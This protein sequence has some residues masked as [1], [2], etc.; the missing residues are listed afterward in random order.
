MGSNVGGKSEMCD[1]ITW[2]FQQNI[3]TSSLKWV[4]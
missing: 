1:G 3:N 4:A 2:S